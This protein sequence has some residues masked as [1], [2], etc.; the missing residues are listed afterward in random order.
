MALVIGI[1]GGMGSGKSTVSAMFEKLGA[2]LI[3][4]DRLAHEVLRE[5]QIARKIRDTWGPG[6]LM[7]GTVDRKK[8]AE[9]VFSSQ[10]EIERLNA[11]VHP[12]VV[13]SIKETIARSRDTG[14][15][16]VVVVDAP[17]LM[18]AGLDEICDVLV[19]V[20]A[21][22]EA[23]KSRVL[24]GKGLPEAELERREKFQI[25]LDKKGRKAHYTIDNSNSEL[26]TF[27]QVS[28]LW[29]NLFDSLNE[30]M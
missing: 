22:P 18:E 21:G 6:V 10:R 26:S 7:D 13:G 30:L 29:S 25:S 14:K 2:T 12:P 16:D 20:E 5:P 15:P 28:V 27:E 3:D 1:L 11:I 24:A 17:L 4:A 19:F 23:R 8:L 9:A